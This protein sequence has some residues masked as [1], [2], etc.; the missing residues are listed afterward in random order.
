MNALRKYLKLQSKLVSKQARLS[1]LYAEIAKGCNEI[2]SINH[3]SCYQ[4]DMELYN[5]LCMLDYYDL[6]YIYDYN[7]EYDESQNNSI[8]Y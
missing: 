1:Y 6:G 5:C 2:N 7:K 3:C 8:F 4:S